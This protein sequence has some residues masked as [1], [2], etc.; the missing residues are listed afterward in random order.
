[1]P[2]L[3]AV[4]MASNV[5]ST[6]T[7]TG[8]PQNMMIGSFSQISYTRFAACLAPV[9]LVGLVLTAALLALLYRAEL[10]GEGVRPRLPRVRGSIEF[11]WRVPW[12]PPRWW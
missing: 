2:H 10:C 8:H 9:A 4:A 1:M 5:G 3:L 12:R 7:I 6:A 11:W